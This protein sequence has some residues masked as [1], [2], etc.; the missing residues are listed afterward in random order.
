[1]SVIGTM[2]ELMNGLPLL[3]RGNDVRKAEHSR[4]SVL[5]PALLGG[6]AIPKYRLGSIVEERTYCGNRQYAQRGI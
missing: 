6:L 2:R 3:T 4:I 1:M 5:E